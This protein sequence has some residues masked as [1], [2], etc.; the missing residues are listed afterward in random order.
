MAIIKTPDQR[1][2]VFISSTINE[3]AD[4]RKAA[5]EAISN[6]RLI[7][8]F[9]EAGA[10]PHPPR[11]LYS[12]Y[13]EQ[14]HIFLGIYWNSYG[15]VAPGAEISGLEDEYRLCG[16]KKPKLIYVKKSAERQPQLNG[17]LADIEKSE[18]A[19][20]QAFSDAAELQ[21][22]IE[23]DLSV[24]M[25]EIFE[26]ALLDNKQSTRT[27]QEISEITHHKLVELPHI[28]SEIY[29]RDE[30]LQKVS[31][32]ITKPGIA[33]VTLLG[34]GGTG[35]TTLSV[36]IGH[37]VKDKFK[38]G[39]VFIPLAPVTDYKLVAATIAEVLGVQ[40]SGK[41]P[42]EQTLI[43]F[44]SDKN[45]LLVLDNFEQVIDASNFVSDIITRCKD[46]KILVTSRTSLHIRNERI[47]NLA[48]LALPDEDKKITPD[49]LRNFPAIELF[50]ERALEVNPK[51]QFT[52]ENTEAIIEI[53]QRMDG[54]PLAIE[55]AA[56][57][58]RFFQPAA[59]MSRIEKTLDLVSKGHK[60][61][62]ER[63]Q[64]LRGAI[65]WS[66][67][68]LTE[69]TQKIFRQLGVFKRSWTM[70][71]ADAIINDISVDIEEMTE[72]L[73]DVSLIKPVLVNHS[74]EPRFNM[75]QTVHEYAAEMLEKSAEATATKKRYADYFLQLCVQSERQLWGVNSE[76]WFDKFEF[77]FQNIR[78]AFYIFVENNNY[79]KAWK[80]FYLLVPYWHM[81]TGLN[82][83][84]TWMQAA[85]VD[86]KI[87]TTDSDLAQISNEVKGKTFLWAAYVE[88]FLL[89]IE[90]GYVF[91]YRSE[92]LLRQTGDDASLISA[93]A[94]DG[95]YGVYMKFPDAVEK[96]MEAEKLAEY[97]NDLFA[98]TSI[99]LWPIQHYFETG[100]LEKAKKNLEDIRQLAI[101]NDIKYAAGLLFIIQSGF[102]T[103]E[104]R[105]E[106]SLQYSRETYNALPEKGYKS[107]K[108][109]CMAHIAV[110][111]LM[112]D[113]I[114]E[115]E[116]YFLKSLE[117]T[118]ECGEKEGEFHSTLLGSFL[119]GKKHDYEKACKLF[120]ALNAFIEFSKYPLI[121]TTKTYY[122]MTRDIVLPDEKDVQRKK[123]YEEGKKMKI[124]EAVIYAMKKN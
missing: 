60:D 105:Y 68:L 108:S 50:V 14:S 20:Y 30:D 63:Q 5:R 47:Y 11:D 13:L 75:L 94:M 18:T 12:A 96:I 103:L 97:S 116:P 62:P 17:L 22:L 121:S 81:R 115:A 3:L 104:G 92:E 119:Y 109:A 28:R 15:W 56:A 106:E 87:D 8:V 44:L 107:Y 66:Y 122:E 118:R 9:F 25:S 67:N 101:D 79:E 27:A 57:R 21:K 113:K 54:L 43:D 31:E 19:C 65:E 10:R 34:A 33:L 16:N 78:A 36:H 90:S 124:E 4:E 69:D 117:L 74:S 45:F 41:Q 24:L 64:T 61:L 88:F 102:M 82:E 120:G 32:L 2:R 46:V 1:V 84:S 111:L 51:L 83:A 7:P 55:L 99:Y 70:E 26:N 85:K 59:L 6:L 42:I 72:R 80:L 29:G 39:V 93:L 48:P 37:Q 38:D 40:D 114:A 76:P 89:K 77:E 53:C 112:M 98:K 86:S 110:S 49:E 73:L 71:A 100:E 95:G 123:W 91:V 35:K 58:T 23:N 52:K